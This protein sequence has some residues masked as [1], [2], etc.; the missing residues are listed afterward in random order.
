MKI[1]YFARL[2]ETFGESEELSLSEETKVSEVI[3]MLKGRGDEW[4][5]ELSRPYRV[6]VNAKM[7]GTDAWISD[8]DELAIFPP[9]TG[10]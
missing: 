3:E 4:A 5:G 6:A 2:R 8:D 1:R 7:A 10:G 9:V